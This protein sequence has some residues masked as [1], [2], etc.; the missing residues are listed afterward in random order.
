MIQALKS[1]FDLRAVCASEFYG[2]RNPGIWIRDDICTPKTD[3]YGYAD[4]TMEDNMFNR[5]LENYGWYAEPYD[6]ETIMLYRI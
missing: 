4:A 3:Y 5:W 1:K 6:A 2:S